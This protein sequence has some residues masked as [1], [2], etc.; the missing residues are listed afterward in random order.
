[1]FKT[2]ASIL[3]ISLFML[4]QY[5]RQLAYLQCKVENFSVKTSATTCD[6]EKDY[7]NDVGKDDNQLP[8][9]KTHVHISL[10]EYYVLNETNFHLIT[11]DQSIRFPKEP[12][13]FLSSFN[14]NIFHPPQS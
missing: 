2:I 7:G 13:S 5:G 8:P 9:Q 3:L 1:M 14:G 11:K 10:D 12:V 6:C 4:T